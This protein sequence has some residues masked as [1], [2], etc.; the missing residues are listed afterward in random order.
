MKSIL[1]G[2]SPQNIYM[3]LV[4][5]CINYLVPSKHINSI[6]Q[7]SRKHDMCVCY[8]CN[9]LT[10]LVQ[11]PGPRPTEAMEVRLVAVAGYAVH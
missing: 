9:L 7:Y 5:L 11:G 1:Y 4:I 8:V 10:T 6:L 2:T 3:S